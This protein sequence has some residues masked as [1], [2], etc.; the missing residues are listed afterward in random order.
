M[1]TRRTGR[2]LLARLERLELLAVGVPETK[3]IF[4][5]VR[6]L[7]KDYQGERH[8]VIAKHLPN[9]GD[10]EWVEFEEVPGP[11]P[12]LKAEHGQGGPRYVYICFVAPYPEDS[13]PN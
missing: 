2:T 3:L 8:T 12:R 6:R 7:P 10:Q 4:G 1:R 11:K 5:N 13:D 9:R